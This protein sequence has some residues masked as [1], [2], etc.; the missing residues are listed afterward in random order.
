MI[1]KDPVWHSVKTKDA[2]EPGLRT[3][4]LPILSTVK[5]KKDS[6][7]RRTGVSFA[8]CPMP[9][10][11]FARHPLTPIQCKTIFLKQRAAILSGL[12]AALEPWRAFVDRRKGQPEG[13]PVR[14]PFHPTPRHTPRN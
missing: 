3:I 10:A 6:R 1:H 9:Y 13:F 8:P 11:P 14:W 5:C 12:S 7:I 2:P 4:K